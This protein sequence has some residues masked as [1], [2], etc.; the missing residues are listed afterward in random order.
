M[1]LVVFQAEDGIRDLVRSRGLGDVYKRQVMHQAG[2]FNGA[3]VL[4]RTHSSV[5]TQRPAPGFGTCCLNIDGVRYVFTGAPAHQMT[6]WEGRDALTAVLH[7][8]QGVDGL[9]KNMRPETRIQGIIPEGGKAP[10]AVSYTHL[11]LPTS[12][13]SVDLGGRRIIKKKRQ[14][15][16]QK[17]SKIKQI[18]NLH[19]S[20]REDRET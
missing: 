14:K 19:H 20:M 11:T 1:E 2:V 17:Q 10:N 12:D 16:K 7:L 13:P 8:F 4:V 18:T 9:R 5:N 3:D 15:K 6:A